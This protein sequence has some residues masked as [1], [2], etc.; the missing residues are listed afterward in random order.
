MTKINTSRNICNRI[1][2]TVNPNIDHCSLKACNK[3]ENC[4][5]N[6]K[7]QIQNFI[8]FNLYYAC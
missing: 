6:N 2:P 1:Q 8:E 4:D 7:Q 3:D 5:S